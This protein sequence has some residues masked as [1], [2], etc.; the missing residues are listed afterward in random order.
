MLGLLSLMRLGWK[1]SL[2]CSRD[3]MRKKKRVKVPEAP[4]RGRPR[5]DFTLT[6]AIT[7]WLQNSFIL[8]SAH[9]SGDS[10]YL[11]ATLD[12]FHPYMLS[13]T[14]P[15]VPLELIFTTSL[16]H[17]SDVLALALIHVT[18]DISSPVSKSHFLMSCSLV[19]VRLIFK[20]AQSNFYGDVAR[21]V[22]GPHIGSTISVDG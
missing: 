13:S 20:G 6:D 8:L 7:S 10:L 15:I 12:F 2:S 18:L 14:C 9:L 21:V 4:Q 19:K 1:P 22:N 11:L 3:R 16:L 17:H 5:R